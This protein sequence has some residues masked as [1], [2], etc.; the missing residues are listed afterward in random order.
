VNVAIYLLNG[1]GAVIVVYVFFIGVVIIGGLLLVGFFL[2][3]WRADVKR[4]EAKQNYKSD[5]QPDENGEVKIQECPYCS[6]EIDA[7]TTVCPNC[8]LYME[9]AK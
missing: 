9:P 4:E 3:V 2:L 7:N 5:D 6:T 8:Q 1:G